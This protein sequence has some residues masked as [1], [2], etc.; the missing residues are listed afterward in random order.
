MSCQVLPSG[1]VNINSGIIHSGN[2]LLA[3]AETCSMIEM[4]PPVEQRN[5]EMQV[6]M[7]TIDK[8]KWMKLKE[9]CVNLKETLDLM[10]LRYGNNADFVVLHK[11]AS[12]IS[13]LVTYAVPT[14][15]QLHSQGNNGPNKAHTPP[16]L[17]RPRVVLK[18]KKE[19]SQNDSHSSGEDDSKRP[20]SRRQRAKAAPSEELYC[21]SCGET[22]TCEWR[23]GPD[24][25]KSLCNACGIHYA[26]IVK[27]EETALHSYKPKNIKLDMLLNHE[28]ES[29]N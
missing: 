2:S 27:K 5:T 23:R 3:M 4:F 12:D 20:K 24:G 6:P 18:K 16:P 8:E 25:Y 11:K 7:V 15:S 29:V 26:K 14:E 19:D 10:Q 21:R 1:V 9:S 22:Q 28:E 17:T 13:S